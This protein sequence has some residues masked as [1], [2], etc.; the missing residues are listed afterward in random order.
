MSEELIRKIRHWLISG[1]DVLD[2]LNK[3]LD[4][5]TPDVPVEVQLPEND[6][7]LAKMKRGIRTALTQFDPIGQSQEEW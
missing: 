1:I 3:E 6:I 7:E 5:R 4:Q 2:T